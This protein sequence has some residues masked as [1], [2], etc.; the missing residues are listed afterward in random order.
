MLSSFITPLEIKASEIGLIYLL[1]IS[2]PVISSNIF[3][4][5]KT[6]LSKTPLNSFV[7]SATF[8]KILLYVCVLRFL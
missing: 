6:L 2:Q 7:T 1:S 8:N 4:K 3:M 5:I